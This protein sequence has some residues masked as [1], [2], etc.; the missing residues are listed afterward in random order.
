[1]DFKSS[2][3]DG[4]VKTVVIVKGLFSSASFGIAWA[5]LKDTMTSVVT[6]RLVAKQTSACLAAIPLVTLVSLTP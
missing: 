6:S 2:L 4:G 3:P 1:M 5:I